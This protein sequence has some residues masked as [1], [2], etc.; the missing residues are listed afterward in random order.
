MKRR[1]ESHGGSP[2]RSASRS[3]PRKSLGDKRREIPFDTARR[4]PKDGEVGLVGY[5]IDFNRDFYGYR[6]R[7]PLEEVEADIQ[8]IEKDIVS[9]L[10]ELAG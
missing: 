1:N 4:D 8:A 6:P 9:M 3:A 10:R 5:E 7:R 2:P